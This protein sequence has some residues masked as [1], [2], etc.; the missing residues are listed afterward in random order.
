V[1]DVFHAAGGEIVEQDY[2]VAA[3]K[4]AFSQ[5][6]SDET[7]TA[8]DQKAQFSSSEF[9][10]VV[11]VVNGDFVTGFETFIGRRGFRVLLRAVALRIRIIPIG[12]VIVRRGGIH[13]VQNDTE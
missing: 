1:A 9:L 4:K 10:I 13:C 2:G 7:G 3:V 5:M 11:V 8:G 12:I 6:G